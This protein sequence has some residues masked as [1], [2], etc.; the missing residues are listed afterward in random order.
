MKSAIAAAASGR[1][2]SAR[3][4]SAAGRRGVHVRADGTQPP[5]RWNALFQFAIGAIG[6]VVVVGGGVTLYFHRIV[7]K[8]AVKRLDFDEAVDYAIRQI[9][10]GTL[11]MRS[12]HRDIDPTLWEHPVKD[13]VKAMKRCHA[14][15]TA[16][17]AVLVGLNRTGKTLTAIAVANELGNAVYVDVNKFNETSSVKE[18]LYDSLVQS[19]TMRTDNAPMRG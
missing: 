3:A 4:T 15:G 14:T 12:L 7:E 13:V 11:L 1:A 2:Q 5:P 17:W 16:H 9:K 8:G 10:K 19:H 18:I 6:T